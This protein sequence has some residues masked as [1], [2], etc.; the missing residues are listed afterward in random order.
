[1]ET[2]G[3]TVQ[4]LKYEKYAL[5]QSQAVAIYLLAFLN[6][7]S[8]I[9]VTIYPLLSLQSFALRPKGQTTKC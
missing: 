6:D 8:F 4:Q 2:V 3:H 9:V 5:Q 7:I 1:M